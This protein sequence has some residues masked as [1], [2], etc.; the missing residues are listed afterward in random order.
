MVLN[1]SQ[2]DGT[3]GFRLDGID[4]WDQSGFS[5]D[6]AGDLNGDGIDDLV[7]GAFGA[8]ADDKQRS[9]ETYVVF[10]TKAGFKASLSLAALDGSNGFRLDGID[11]GDASGVSVAGAGDLNGDGFD[12][13][14]LGADM[15]KPGGKE[16]AGQSYVV[17]GTDHGFAASLDLSALDGSN[18]FRINGIDVRDDS[19]WQ[20]A[21]AGDVNGDGIDDA[22]IGAFR[23]DDFAG[24]SYVV[25]GTRRGFPA[26]LE[27]SA[28]DGSNGFRLAGIDPGDRLGWSVAGAGDV[29]NDGI[30]DLIVGSPHAD[31]GGKLNAGESYVVFGTDAGF[32][33]RI[34]VAALDGSDGF[35]FDG[36]SAR[37]YAGRSLSGAGDVN[38]DG[39]DDL[40]IG[41]RGGDPGGQS[42]AGES[43]VVFGTEA[44]FGSSFDLSTLDGSNGFRLDGIAPND[45][46]GRWVAAAGDFNG[47]GYDDVLVGASGVNADAGAT[48]LVYGKAGGF[49]ASLELSALDGSNGFRIDG[50]DPGDTS[51]RA[52]AGAGDLNGDGYD[53]LIIGAWHGD[54]GGRLNAGESYV[55]FGF[56]TGD[57]SERLVGTPGADDLSGFAGNDTILGRGGDDRL[58]GGSG[59]DALVGGDGDDHLFGGIGGDEMLG[60]AGND[61]LR[62]WTGRDLLVGGTGNDTLAGEADADTLGGSAGNDV[63]SGGEGRDLLVGGL[64]ND[65]LRGEYSSDTLAGG[66]GA[67]QLLGGRNDDRLLGEAGNDRLT[68]G[69]GADVFEFRQGGGRDLVID[70]GIGADRID[71]S[72]FGFASGAEVLALGAESGS[73]VIFALG[74]G[75]HV[76]LAGHALADLG[77]GD[78]LV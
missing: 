55:V 49:A 63:L 5:V 32:A 67:D 21:A 71:V 12:D 1:L 25:F 47:D 48:Y 69:E 66:A 57:G 17:F 13:L 53:D 42:F 39:I 26:D 34:E 8:N 50:I 76:I 36:I 44:G 16:R 23:P 73:D 6:G 2:L 30:D 43:Y 4:A 7:V 64:G 24:E 35:R 40:I 52:A 75:A 11:R 60:G 61:G 10:G 20:V 78:F 38:G 15:A 58:F 3:N 27:L 62:G 31:A 46:S 59:A 65:L 9:G 72:A 51:G 70:F 74:L 22:I 19:G 28:L 29:N 37:D 56:G 68:G 45:R 18:G 41:A 54:P 14:I 77:A 33:A